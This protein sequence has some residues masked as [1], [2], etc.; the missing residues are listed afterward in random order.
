MGIYKRKQGRKKKEKK[1]TQKAIKKK[2]KRPRKKRKTFFSFLITFLVEFLFSSLF[3]FF[4]Y[5]FL[6]RVLF[7]LLSY[8]FPRQYEAGANC[9][10]RGHKIPAIELLE[11]VQYAVSLSTHT[12]FPP[13]QKKN[14][15]RFSRLKNIPDLLEYLLLMKRKAK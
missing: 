2:R 6:S 8:K 1:S 11:L 5:R 14:D 13:P 10:K 3:S 12:G 15:A 4:L 7:F 9:L